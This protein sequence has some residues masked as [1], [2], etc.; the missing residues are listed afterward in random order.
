MQCVCTA[1]LRSVLHCQQTRCQASKVANAVH[2]C[3]HGAQNLPQRSLLLLWLRRNSSAWKK[4]TKNYSLCVVIAIY[5]HSYYCSAAP[6]MCELS[7]DE[8]NPS[9]PFSQKNAHASNS[10][11]LW[12][13]AVY[14]WCTA[15]TSSIVA[16]SI[17]LK[18]H[19]LTQS[20]NTT[21]H[22]S[23]E[24]TTTRRATVFH[25]IVDTHT[26]T[27]ARTL[28][29]KQRA[30]LDA[31]RVASRSTQQ[32]ALRGMWCSC[33]RL[34]LYHLTAATTTAQQNERVV[35][36]ARHDE[37]AYISR[38]RERESLQA[39]G[40][41]CKVAGLGGR[42]HCTHIVPSPRFTHFHRLIAHLKRFTLSIVSVVSPPP[43]LVA[44]VLS[45]YAARGYSRDRT[46][47]RCRTGIFQARSSIFFKIRIL[48]ETF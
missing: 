7:S 9:S 30:R 24:C 44:Y 5:N 2:G 36:C 26:L 22:F 13:V 18:T 34:A 1:Y 23:L 16:S 25:S 47:A 6:V 12:I 10:A 14:E 29:Y 38:E 15:T 35:F 45:A 43:P 46:T 37:G 39:S 33:C 28:S 40:R 19:T 27:L 48:N 4:F 31:T 20:S 8:E 21:H 41:D 17:Y 3:L 32:P 42:A 11:Q